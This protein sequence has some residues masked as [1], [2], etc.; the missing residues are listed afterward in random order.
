MSTC[1][2]CEFG[3]Q[4]PDGRLYCALYDEWVSGSDCCED[5]QRARDWDDEEDNYD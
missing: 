1:D 3:E 5:H 2:N 4:Q